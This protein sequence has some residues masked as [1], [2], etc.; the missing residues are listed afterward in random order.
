MRNP[1]SPKSSYYIYLLVTVL[2]SAMIPL[3]ALAATTD[4]SSIIVKLV[5]GLSP[6][7]QAVVIARNRGFEKSSVP[8]LRLHIDKNWIEAILKMSHNHSLYAQ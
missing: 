8:A 3:V 2:I 5:D 1:R 7:E 6:G 4:T